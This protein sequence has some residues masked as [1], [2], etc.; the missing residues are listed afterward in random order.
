M[1]LG[2]GKPDRFT[3]NTGALLRLDHDHKKCQ[4]FVRVVTSCF[5]ASIYI[6]AEL[7]RNRGRPS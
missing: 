6:L 5:K 2:R 4:R 3:K 1:F 7:K